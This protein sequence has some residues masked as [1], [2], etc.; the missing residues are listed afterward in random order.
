MIEQN[1]L[2]QRL[3]DESEVIAIDPDS[4][5]LL[6]MYGYLNTFA[7]TLA[8]YDD[9]GENYEMVCDMMNPIIDVLDMMLSSHITSLFCRG[10]RK[11]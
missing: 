9:K 8:N 5:E 1:K 4:R 6:K 3:C 10:N 11:R 7:D 2:L